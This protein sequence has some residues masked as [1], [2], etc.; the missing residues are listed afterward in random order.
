MMS[1]SVPCGRY[2]IGVTYPRP[3]LR[4]RWWT[5]TMGAPSKFPPTRPAFARNSAMVFAF[6]SSGSLMPNSCRYAVTCAALARRAVRGCPAQSSAAAATARLAVKQVRSPHLIMVIRD[7]STAGQGS[8]ERR[9]ALLAC[10][11]RAV[12]HDVAIGA[13]PVDLAA[14][15]LF[16]VQRRVQAAA[17]QQV[18]V[19]ARFRY[20]APVDD[21]D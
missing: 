13:P 8:G 1:G 6:Q 10:P 2:I 15:E 20:A 9:L 5:R 3:L 16:L 7:R 11:H 18:P 12:R 14:F 21:I 4:P 19:R 17:A